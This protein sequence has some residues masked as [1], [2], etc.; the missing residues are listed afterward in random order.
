MDYFF[1]PTSVAVIGASATPGK[2]GYEV[3]RSVLASGFKGKIC[4]IN[5]NKKTIGGLKVYQTIDEVPGDIDLAV[6]AVRASL[7][8]Q[9][10]EQ[11]SAKRV[12]GAVVIS[13][14]FREMGDGVLNLRETW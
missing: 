13:G 11:C 3:L 8:P 7:V 4:P 10:I 6:V 1:R 2:I 5:P 9:V 12:K 14:G